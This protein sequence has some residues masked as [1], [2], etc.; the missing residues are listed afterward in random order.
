MRIESLIRYY[1]QDMETLSR[2]RAVSTVHLRLAFAR[3][4]HPFYPPS[5]EVR[6]FHCSSLRPFAAFLATAARTIS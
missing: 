5:V 1:S 6:R 3:G 2:R 4:L